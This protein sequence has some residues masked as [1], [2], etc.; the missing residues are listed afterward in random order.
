MRGEK[1]VSAEVAELQTQYEQLYG[2]KPSEPS[3]NK[4]WWLNKKITA[5]TGYRSA[6]GRCSSME[7]AP[8]RWESR[9][10]WLAACML[11]TCCASSTVYFPAIRNGS[12]ISR[13]Q[14]LSPGSIAGLTRIHQVWLGPREAPW[15]WID[16]WRCDY[17]AHYLREEG[18]EH[19]LWTED[20]IAQLQPPL[21]NLM[22]CD[23]TTR[24]IR[25]VAL[26]AAEEQ[27]LCPRITLL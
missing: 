18:V 21:E 15:S 24:A 11:W 3:R 20:E 4:D 2:K 12:C 27:L 16:T 5:R 17:M 7:S 10:S 1:P 19:F 14:T 9:P 6:L 8:G 25:P 26:P 22:L 23:N 13:A